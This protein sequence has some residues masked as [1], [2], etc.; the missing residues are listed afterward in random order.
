MA[1][2]VLGGP[3]LPGSSDAVVPAAPADSIFSTPVGIKGIK[4]EEGGH[5]L[6][7]LSFPFEN[8]PIDDPDPDNQSTLVARILEWF[9]STTGIAT[10]DISRL[11]MRQNAPNPFNPV[12][13]IA[14]TVP[15]NAGSVTLT[16]Y[17]VSGRVV[18][19]LVD[20]PL[21]AGPHSVAWNGRDDSG[22]NL[23]S[24]VYFARLAAGG[25]SLLKKMTLL[26]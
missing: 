25:E 19:R 15:E 13:K 18:R 22:E 14:F 21:S 8:A 3:I 16:V 4:V 17:N 9:G 7:F 6:V 1:L 11:A 20:G 23:A 26:K 10:D 12:T 24:G 2:M 5:K